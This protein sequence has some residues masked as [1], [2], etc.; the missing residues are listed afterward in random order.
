M[1]LLYSSPFSATSLT[2]F[3]PKGVY[4]SFQVAFRGVN[5]ATPKTRADLGN[6]QLTYNGNP[7]VNVDLELLSFLNDMKGGFS[8]FTSTANGL[9]NAQI[10]LPCGRFGDKNNSYN[11]TDKDKVYFKLDFPS[12][13][14]I[15][16]TVYIYG[17]HKMG[18][19]NYLY[20]LTSR[21]IVS[22]GSGVLSDVHRLPNV[23]E[24]YLKNT[25]IISSI[26]IVRDNHTVIDGLREDIQAFSDYHNQVESS[27]QLIELPLNIST[28]VREVLSQE[29]L[30]KYSFSGSGTLQQYF[31]YNILTPKQAV[32]SVQE[33]EAELQK[34]ISLGVVSV[35]DLPKP[36]QVVVK[37]LQQL[38]D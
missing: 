6:I 33:I 29:I 12:L 36:A 8:T 31:A 9:L 35:N 7:I 14:N 23:S 24:M 21:N 3:L 1:K 16:G 2:F 37:S 4:G 25:S 10:N 5:N 15:S 22:Q 18:V 11:V 27:S 28:D 20:C 19:Q 26:Q 38:A 17:V 13:S 34:K 30:Y 32:A